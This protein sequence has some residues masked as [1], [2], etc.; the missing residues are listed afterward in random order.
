MY[1]TKIQNEVKEMPDNAKYYILKK[2]ALPEVFLKVVEAKALIEKEKAIT[3]QEAVDL[4]GISRSSFYKYKDFVF[5]LSEGT[6]GQKVTI[7][8]LLGHELGV[9]STILN[10]I[11][12]N[13]GNILTINQDIPINNIANV[14]ITFDI[15]NLNI[16]L[17]DLMMDIEKSKGVIK[18]NLIAM[19]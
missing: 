6:K 8:M 11:A 12:D 16:K 17:D 3:V 18:L 2:K 7:A 10:K 4:V 5:S 9:L 13:K 1:L 14:S 19:E 15:S